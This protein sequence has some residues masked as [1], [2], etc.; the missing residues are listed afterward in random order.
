[1]NISKNK[2]WSLSRFPDE[3]L[4]HVVE[5]I[6]S[7]RLALQQIRVGTKTVPTHNQ[8]ISVSRVAYSFFAASDSS[9]SA[10]ISL[11]ACPALYSVL[12][13]SNING[14]RNASFINS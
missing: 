2:L 14:R 7:E 1:M 11:I 3:K 8:P 9:A 12:I 10:S 13:C 6:G 4:C 5:H